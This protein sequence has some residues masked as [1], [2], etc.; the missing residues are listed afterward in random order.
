M[1]FADICCSF[2]SKLCSLISYLIA[3]LL[4]F[5]ML[6]SHFSVGTSSFS[7]FLSIFSQFSSSSSSFFSRFSSIS[8]I[9]FRVSAFS[10][11][12]ALVFLKIVAE[13]RSC[14]PIV[15][16][17]EEFIVKFWKVCSVFLEEVAFLVSSGKVFLRNSRNNAKIMKKRRNFLLFSQFSRSFPKECS[18]GRGKTSINT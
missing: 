8:Q 4:I 7:W 12:I 6:A 15:L 11:G 14:S 2:S 17:F 13:S 1:N 10:C 3:E 18:P 9:S 16:I 5:S